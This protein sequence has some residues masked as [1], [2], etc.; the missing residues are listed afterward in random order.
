[1]VIFVQTSQTF[2]KIPEIA[3]DHNFG[4]EYGRDMKFVSKYVA[5]DT[6][7]LLTK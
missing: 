2:R 7:L 3:D 1:M 4:T 6:I 5:L